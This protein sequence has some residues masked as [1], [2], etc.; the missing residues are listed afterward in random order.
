MGCHALLQGIFLTGIDPESL[1]FSTMA[2]RFF[3]TS[4]AW[5]ASICTLLCVKQM[6]NKGLL[7]STENSSQYSV[8]TNMGKES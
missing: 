7:H 1:T 3:T 6:T 4:T 8:M 2:G 5:E